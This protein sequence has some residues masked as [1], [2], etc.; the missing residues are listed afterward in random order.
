M[1][2]GRGLQPRP[3]RLDISIAFE[4]PSRFRLRIHSALIDS[5]VVY[6]SI[7]INHAQSL[8]IHLKIPLYKLSFTAIMIKRIILTITDLIQ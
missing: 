1:H 2:A 6:G 8:I 7:F 3:K 4:T 5:M